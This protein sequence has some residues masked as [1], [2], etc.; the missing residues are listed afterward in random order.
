MAGDGERGSLSGRYRREL[1][2]VS[3]TP[4]SLPTSRMWSM[5]FVTETV[6]P[7]CFEGASSPNPTGNLRE[8][9]DGAVGSVGGG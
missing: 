3:Y 7:V 6:S 1:I 2:K 4:L 8:M 9:Q 5:Q